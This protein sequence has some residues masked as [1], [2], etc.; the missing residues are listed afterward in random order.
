MLKISQK[1]FSLKKKKIII[2]KHGL[3]SSLKRKNLKRAY[4][5]IYHCITLIN[6]IHHESLF[7][8]EKIK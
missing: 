4:L 2:K 8:K 3:E 1:C 7:K 5:T 6:I